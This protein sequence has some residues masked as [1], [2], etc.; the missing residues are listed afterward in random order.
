MTSS[1]KFPDA[2]VAMGGVLYSVD[3]DAKVYRFNQLDPV[4]NPDETIGFIQN[5]KT[6]TY[7]KPDDKGHRDM[8]A[9]GVAVTV[10]SAGLLTAACVTT[11]PL[12]GPISLFALGVLTATSYGIVNDLFACKKCIQYFTIGHTSIHKRLLKTENPVANAVVWGIHATWILGAVAGTLFALSAMATGLAVAPVL[13]YLAA[14]KITGSLIAIAYASYQ[15]KKEEEYYSKKENKK[16][17]DGYFQGM[18]QGQL[19]NGNFIQ[20][21]KGFHIVD[22]SLIPEDKRA[23]YM[24][25]G[26][27]NGA[28]YTVMPALG[29]VMLIAITTLGLI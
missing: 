15:S 6:V 29:V 16:E 13:P 8:Y 1:I 25:V 23:A 19:L 26:A 7:E 24:A 17:L 22:L 21:R 28:G 11:F 27:R 20:P 4:R 5:G 18:C 12:S 9:I 14:A 2:C 3:K 10:I